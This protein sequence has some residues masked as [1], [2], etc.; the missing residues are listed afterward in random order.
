VRI[1]IN[2]HYYTGIGVEGLVYNWT[3]IRD[4]DEGEVA[5]EVYGGGEGDQVEEGRRGVT[6]S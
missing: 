1:F 2:W 5:E 6:D 3:I 4:G